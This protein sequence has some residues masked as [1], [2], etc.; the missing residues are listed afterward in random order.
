MRV[1]TPYIYLVSLICK[2][3]L[4]RTMKI[5]TTCYNFILSLLILNLVL[6]C[7]VSGTTTTFTASLA[8]GTNGSYD[9]E[10]I[11]WDSDVTKTYSSLGDTQ[12]RSAAGRRA[13]GYHLAVIIFKLSAIPN[14]EY[15]MDG[16]SVT[17]FS[18]TRGYGR[19][20]LP[21][22]DL[23]LVSLTDSFEL[24]TATNAHFT[25]ARSG[26]MVA[27]DFLPSNR[28]QITA[29]AGKQV[30]TLSA[31]QLTSLTTAI[32]DAGYDGTTE[33]YLK[34]A[35]TYNTNTPAKADTDPDNNAYAGFYRDTF[36]MTIDP[37]IPE[38]STYALLMGLG[39]CGFIFISKR[40]SKR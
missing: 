27:E 33:K 38:P 40:R 29:D 30:E 39:V 34:L 31:G 28:T 16:A 15:F 12:F 2:K 22:L 10:Q 4:M 14:N 24:P 6:V 32:K 5:T 36:S 1:Y 11:G 20:G 8:N 7:S 35:I 9:I 19:H 18:F 3:L 17:N 37:V 13:N 21:K 25:A 23:R 26:T